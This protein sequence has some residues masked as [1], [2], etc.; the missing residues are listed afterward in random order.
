MSMTR[1]DLHSLLDRIPE[2][3]L[4]IAERF[5]RFLSTEPI[6]PRFA[7]SIRKGIA[8][9]DGGSSVVYRDLGEMAEKILE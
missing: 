7:Q 8:E 3:E 2:S 9:A 4:P 1:D 5:L 6:G